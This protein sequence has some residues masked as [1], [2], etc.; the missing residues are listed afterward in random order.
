[1]SSV[2]GPIISFVCENYVSC[3]H[4]RF[5][6]HTVRPSRRWWY[7]LWCLDYYV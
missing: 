4:L 6:A 7:P 5:S 3:S 2:P 1:M